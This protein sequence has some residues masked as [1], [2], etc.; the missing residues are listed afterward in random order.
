MTDLTSENRALGCELVPRG[1]TGTE[2]S[3]VCVPCL[4]C[5]STHCQD[6]RQISDSIKPLI[7]FIVVAWGSEL[8]FGFSEYCKRVKNTEAGLLQQHWNYHVSGAGAEASCF[9]WVGIEGRISI[10]CSTEHLNVF[11]NPICVTKIQQVFIKKTMFKYS[12]ILQ[13]AIFILYVDGTLSS[14]FDKAVAIGYI[15]I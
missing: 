3:A 8:S 9:A 14:P 1:T 13:D 5:M 6:L 2:N 12:S 7:L 4:Y 11:T 10:F 15:V